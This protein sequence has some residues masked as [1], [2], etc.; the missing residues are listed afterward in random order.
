MLM[1]VHYA[2]MMSMYGVC[3]LRCSPHFLPFRLLL[4]GALM[5]LVPTF[6]L[7]TRKKAP[8]SASH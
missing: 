3:V 4:L 2:L 1:I 7:V 6:L 5:Q 8:L